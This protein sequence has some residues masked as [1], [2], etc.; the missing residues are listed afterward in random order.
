MFPNLASG[1]ER[2]TLRAG[3]DTLLEPIKTTL[4]GLEGSRVYNLLDEYRQ[5]YGRTARERAFLTYHHW[6]GGTAALTDETTLRLFDL[7]PHHLSAVE[8]LR[9]IQSLRLYA[10]ERLDPVAIRVTVAHRSDLAGVV[11]QVQRLLRRICDIEMP[12]EALRLQNWL[13]L[14][15]MPALARLAR[16]TENLV[17]ARRLADLIVQITTL[18]RLRALAVPDVSVLVLARFEIPT[19]TVSIRF[20]ES[21]WKEN[22]MPDDV[23]NDEDFLVRLQDLALAQERQDGTMSYVDFVMRTLTPEEQEKLRAIAVAE[24]LRTEILLRELQVKTLAARG[25]IDATIATAETLKVQ[26]HN[27]KITS[28]HATASGT[29]R[30]EITHKTRPCYIAT[31]CYGDPAH[32]DVAALRHFRD[33]RLLPT[34]PGRA[35][36]TLYNLLSPPL[37]RH[38]SP[39]SS[40]SAFLRRRL[41]EPWAR[42]LTAAPLDYPLRSQV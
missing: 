24:G 2:E 23:E 27:S 3:N 10:L 38:L 28:E 19:A 29:T 39:S 40:I 13:N 16:E 6:R 20:R 7:L 26:K 37:A 5:R 1:G 4:L 30:I 42:R 18:F 31:A 15:E 22:R 41:L 36:V 11:V 21:F 35:L 17:A 32:P 14:G 8:K 12:D 33:N 9:L 34:L 25:D